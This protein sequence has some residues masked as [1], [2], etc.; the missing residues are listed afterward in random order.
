MGKKA[1]GRAKQSFLHGALILTASMAVVRIIG[2]L[3]KIPLANILGGE[4]NGYFSA[5]YDLYNPLYALATAG[6]PIAISRMVSE[7][8]ARKRFRDVRQVHRVSKPIFLLTGTIGTIAMMVGAFIYAY[9]IKAPEVKYATLALAPTILFVCLMSIYR[10]YYEGLRN[11]VPTALSEVIEAVCKLV[12]GLGIAYGVISYGLNEYAAKG[13]VF[14]KAYETESLARSATLP[15]AA[16]GAI[17]GISIGAMV[18]FLYLVFRHH[19]HGD[20]IT[21][22]ELRCSPRAKPTR[23]TVKTLVSIAIPIGLGAIIMNVAGLIDSTLILRRL[24]D[25]MRSNPLALLDEYS[26]LINPEIV[27]RGNTHV[28]L[29]GCYS[30]AITIMMLISGVT[31]V[32]SISALPSVTTAWAEGSYKKIKYNIEAVLRVTTLVTIPSG[33]GLMVLSNPIM[34][35]VYG[36]QGTRSEVAI[37][38]NVL[39]MLGLAAIFASTSTPICSMLQA[40]GRVDLPVKL[41]SVGMVIKIILN[42]TLVGIPQ[43]NIQGAGVGTMVCYAMITVLSLYFLC[44]ETKIIPDFMSVFIKPLLAGVSCAVAAYASQGLLSHVISPKIATIFAILIAVIVYIIALFVFCAVTASDI[45]MLPKG[46]KIAKIL[47]KRHWIG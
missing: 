4:G 19:R 28:F 45:R 20:G 2:A 6:F 9:V 27:E 18:G 41:I 40:V 33:L 47:E 26:G 25:T 36:N 23:V 16:A 5:A 31:Q 7:N 13:T 30:Y 44:K 14:G 1:K 21:K 24:S 29:Y 38:S 22:E 37:A 46:E 17:L 15:F 3:F 35:L 42:Y 11:M 10:G 34:E 32:F 12:L 39:I 8:V 43:I